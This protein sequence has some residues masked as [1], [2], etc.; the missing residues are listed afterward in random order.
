MIIKKEED[1]IFIDFDSM[2][3]ILYAFGGKNA[4]ILFVYCINNKIRI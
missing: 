4:V 1:T 3:K 2:I